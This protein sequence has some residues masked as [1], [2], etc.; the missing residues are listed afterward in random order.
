[1]KVV[2]NFTI[3]INC[4]P[5]HL[6]V[7]PKISSCFFQ[8]RFSQPDNFSPEKPYQECEP[9]EQFTKILRDFLLEKVI[10][11]IFQSIPGAQIGRR[12]S[13]ITR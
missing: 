12:V 6:L 3:K 4:F 8:T 10:T 1:M 9:F 7:L 5:Q 2:C 11:N 13:A